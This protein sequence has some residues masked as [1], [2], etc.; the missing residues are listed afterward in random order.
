MLAGMVIFPFWSTF[1]C[2]PISVTYSIWCSRLYMRITAGVFS[3]GR[4]SRMYFGND[5]TTIEIIR[6]YSIGYRVILDC[7][8]IRNLLLS[9][10]VV[11]CC[12]C[13]LDSIVVVF[14]FG[15]DDI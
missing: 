1:V 3:T 4:V 6:F 9:W 12:L 5:S 10:F 8:P 15:A 11:S 13:D 2:S 14:E 7:S